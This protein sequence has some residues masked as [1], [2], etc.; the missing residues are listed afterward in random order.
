MS[1]QRRPKTGRPKGGGKPKW[2]VRYRSPSSREHSKTF[3]TRAEA[4]AY[5]EEQ[6]RLLRRREWVDDSHA[7]TLAELW[8]QWEAAATSPGTKAVRVT[9]G[10]NLGDL[11]TTKITELR[12]SQLRT[13]RTQLREGRPWKSGCDGLARNTRTS[14]WNQVS[15]C[16][17]MA[18][19][20]GLMLT[21]PCR[22]V[23]SGEETEPVDPRSLPSIEQIR[24]AVTLADTTGRDTLAT[25]ILIG[26][27]TGLR[28][29]EV[30]GLHW[31]HIDRQARVLLVERRTRAVTR[32]ETDLGPLKNTSARRTVPVPPRVMSR[33][34]EHR[35][36]H[37]ARD[38]QPIFTRP[39]G[40]LWSSDDIA[41]AMRALTGK[42][43]TFHALRHVYAS[44]LIRQ[45]R[46]VKAVQQM[47]GHKN[48]STTLDTYT[49]M[50]P[51]EDDLVR[52]AA[53]DLVRDVCGMDGGSVDG[54]DAESGLQPR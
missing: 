51:D 33:L 19:D 49:H 7:P 42:Q 4:V 27:A 3:P 13:W 15:G 50:W 12:P 26:V 16:L 28:P 2:I 1:V 22:R 53:N 20:D 54:G 41:S 14:W 21:N 11:A 17:N 36:R 35:L 52:D 29:S 18:V 10:K 5:D 38:D 31:H 44:S 32:G 30:A 23:R 37:P 9:V 34:L 43:W 47:L 48:A 24:Q 46:G 40:G 39:S 6:S 8:P 45:G 25:M